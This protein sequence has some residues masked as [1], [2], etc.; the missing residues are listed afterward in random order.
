MQALIPLS[1]ALAL[2]NELKQ[3]IEAI[4]IDE[5]SKLLTVQRREVQAF[6]ATA[7]KCAAV[8]KPINAPPHS[9]L[10][11]WLNTPQDG[12]GASRSTSASLFPLLSHSA[13]IDS[14]AL[15]CSCNYDDSD[16]IDLTISQLDQAVEVLRI[17]QAGSFRGESVSTNDE[18][19]GNK[20]K[21]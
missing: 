2:A 3:Q 12:C 11:S 17:C 21:Q 5:V 4:V 15:P 19:S 13:L 6:L 7:I 18:E 8:V 9:P 20:M 16:N 1:L 14:G 10:I